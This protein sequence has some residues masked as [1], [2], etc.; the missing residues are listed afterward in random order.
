MTDRTRGDDIIFIIAKE[1]AH[2][3]RILPDYVK[4]SKRFEPFF[5]LIECCLNA[6]QA[7]VQLKALNEF[8]SPRQF[9]ITEWTKTSSC[10]H[11]VQIVIVPK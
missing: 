4:D 5:D 9:C 1:G 7:V 11:Y 6:R 3:V 2:G 10:A 8:L